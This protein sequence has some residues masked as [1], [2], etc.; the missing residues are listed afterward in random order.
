MSSME[1][2]SGKHEWATG[3]PWK[4]MMMWL[5]SRMMYVKDSSSSI[6]TWYFPRSPSDNSSA[7]TASALTTIFDQL[8]KTITKK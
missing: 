3:T 6:D 5:N 8:K 4:A 7:S 2:L 1:E